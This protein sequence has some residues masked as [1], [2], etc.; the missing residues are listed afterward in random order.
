MEQR[1]FFGRF[2]RRIQQEGTK[3]PGGRYFAILLE[4]IFSETPE[5]LAKL[6]FPT[7]QESKFRHAQVITE[8][9]FQPDRQADL[10]FLDA[11]D[12]VLGLVEVKEEDQ[13][14]PGTGEQTSDYLSYIKKTATPE[15]PIYFSYVT[16][17]LPSNKSSLQLE[18][19]G[20]APVYYNDIYYGL[21]KYLAIS[22]QRNRSPM[23]KLFHQYLEEEGAVYQKL[24]SGQDDT[25][26]L[27]L[28]QGLGL[29]NTFGLGNRMTAD[30]LMQTPKLLDVLIGNVEAMSIEFH[31]GFKEHLGNRFQSKFRFRPYWNMEKLSKRLNRSDQ[32]TIGEL[33]PSF[34]DGG[35][36]V[37]L[38]V[39]RLQ[40]KQS[41]YVWFG[42]SFEL[43]I[44]EKSLTKHL[45]ASL[46]LNSN[47]FSQSKQFKSF[48]DHAEAQKAVRGMIRNQ[49]KNAVNSA[50]PPGDKSRLKALGETLS[51]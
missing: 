21:S 22:R 44:S 16:K 9:R 39:G 50:K 26:R 11:E 24:T 37:V 45:F 35:V 27:L 29:G 43:S 13:L 12:R 36:L 5:V 49:L 14:G 46:G 2:K 48:P 51:A 30:R 41:C 42:Y 25:L 23:T 31:N 17:H 1:S 38:S 32:N 3:D 15:A 28:R 47:M 33:D 7:C 34:C 19:N 8:F 4:Q 10:A 18:K 20:V 40:S 6:L